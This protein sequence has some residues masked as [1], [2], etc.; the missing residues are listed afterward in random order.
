MNDS[1][2][3]CQGSG[4]YKKSS[5]SSNMGHRHI[6]GEVSGMGTF[7]WPLR[8]SSMGA[9]QAQDIEVTVGT[10]ASFITLPSSLLRELGI[11]ATGKCG[12]LLP[13]GQHFTAATNRRGTW[14][15]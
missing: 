5:K 1:A 3:R 15:T 14:R 8:I 13:S 11:E 2:R 12:F 6:E 7:K 9:H 10:G 4:I